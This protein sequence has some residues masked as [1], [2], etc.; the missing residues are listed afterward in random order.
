MVVHQ[1]IKIHQEVAPLYWM[2]CSFIPLN[3]GIIVYSS[4]TF[5][6]SLNVQLTFKKTH[7]TAVWV[8]YVTVSSFIRKLL[9]KD[10]PSLPWKNRRGVEGDQHALSFGLFFFLKIEMS[11]IIIVKAENSFLCMCVF[12]WWGPLCQPAWR[13]APCVV[14]LGPQATV[15]TPH[16]DLEL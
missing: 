3:I 13:L 15:L 7:I 14:H 6:S 4:N 1:L 5:L 12:T 10:F 9:L 2:T 11:E 16:S 8:T